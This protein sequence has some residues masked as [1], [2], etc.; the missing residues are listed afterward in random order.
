M[1]MQ[2]TTTDVQLVCL[3]GAT[4]EA[5][6]AATGKLPTF[7]LH[8]GRSVSMRYIEADVEVSRASAMRHSKGTGSCCQDGQRLERA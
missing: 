8:N 3:N 7:S 4:G 2:S 1:T 5:V 6:E